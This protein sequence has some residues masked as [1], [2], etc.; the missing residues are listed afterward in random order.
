MKLLALVKEKDI[1]QMSR[2]IKTNDIWA[3]SYDRSIWDAM[4]THNGELDQAQEVQEL[5]LGELMHEPR[6]K[7]E[8]LPRFRPRRPRCA[9][10][11]KYDAHL[12]FRKSQG[13]SVTRTQWRMGEKAKHKVREVSRSKIKQG[14]EA[15]R[16]SLDFIL[17]DM[18]K[19]ES[20]KQ[21]LQVM[22]RSSWLWYWE[23][24]L[25]KWAR[26]EAK[27]QFRRLK[28]HPDKR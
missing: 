7:Q 14:V 23:Q 12:C 10:T 15:R 9:D 22:Q 21:E 26:T 13:V 27:R 20:S 25:R 6:H 18:E 16:K 4:R 17:H 1:Y 28:S 11:L 8:E 24:T 3:K 2:P 5:F 19:L